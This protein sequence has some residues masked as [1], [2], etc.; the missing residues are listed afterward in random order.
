MAV[1]VRQ[2]PKS[3]ETE[4]GLS[5]TS[6]EYSVRAQVPEETS[7]SSE[8]LLSF[9]SYEKRF[10]TPSGETVETVLQNAS[11]ATVETFPSPSTALVG[12]PYP[13]YSTVSVTE[14][15]PTPPLWVETSSDPEY[16]N[17]VTRHA[18]SV[19]FESLQRPSYSISVET[20]TGSA[21]SESTT[22]SVSVFTR[23]RFPSYEYRVIVPSVATDFVTSFA[24]VPVP[25]SYLATKSEKSLSEREAS[26]FFRSSILFPSESYFHAVPAPEGRTSKSIRPRGSYAYSKVG[27]GVPV[28]VL[29]DLDRT[30]PKRSKRYVVRTPRALVATVS[31]TYSAPGHAP[32]GKEPVPYSKNPTEPPNL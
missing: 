6:Y 16:E 5:S 27:A 15:G 4:T 7:V 25:Y 29:V 13:S 17:S 21:Q 1:A 2:S 31:A 3:A 14:S 23:R 12:F 10:F 26:S 20:V 18:A 19:V 22:P 11:Y 32:S 24:V 28:P 9:R 8:S 30:L